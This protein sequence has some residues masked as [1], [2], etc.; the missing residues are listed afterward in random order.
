[1]AFFWQGYKLG[2]Q[3]KEEKQKQQKEMQPWPVRDVFDPN[4]MVTLLLGGYIITS[5]RSWFCMVLR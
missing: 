5:R 2:C 3:R 1:M 4:G